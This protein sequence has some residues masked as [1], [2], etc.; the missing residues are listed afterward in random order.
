MKTSES[1]TGIAPALIKAQG[2]MSGIAKE[3]NNPAFRSKYVTLDSILDTIRPVLTKHGLML[4][5][6]I[7]SQSVTDDK[8]TAIEVE[9]R[10][11]HASGEWVAQGVVVPITK[12]DAHGFGSALTYGRRYSVSSLLAISAD[13]DD[14]GNAA[15][16]TLPR[17][18][19]GNIVIGEPIKP[20]G[21]QR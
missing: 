14:D 18:P 2:E 19:H 16:N 10:I 20:K 9:S 7:T 13:E 21:L 1:I 4:S 3:G 12:H 17:G 5:Q 15:T 8:V 6:G 11:I